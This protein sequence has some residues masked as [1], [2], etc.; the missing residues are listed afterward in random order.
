MIELHKL[1]VDDIVIGERLPW[2]VMDSSARLLLGEGYIID[3]RS[4]AKEL[5]DR[6]AYIEKSL[7]TKLPNFQRSLTKPETEQFVPSTESPSVLH[8][9]NLAVKRLDVL[10]KNIKKFPEARKS[11]LEIVKLIRTAI[12]L[13]ED[14]ALASMQ[15]N[16]EAGSY[17]VRHCVDTAILALIV[18]KAMKKS[19]QEMQD[20]AAA[21]LT[22]NI[23][24]IELQERL[25]IQKGAIS[26]AD[27]AAIHN[28]PISTIEVLYE[29]GI[30]DTDWLMYVLLHHEHEDG[31]GYP[32]GTVKGEIP[33]NAKI[34]SLADGFC[35][36]IT[37]RGYRKS[38]LPSVA[39]R[40]IFIDNVARVD[41]TLGAYFVKVLGLYPPGTFVQL[42]NKE[43]A[44][45]SQRGTTPTNCTA[46]SMVKPNGELF[47]A[48]MK[49]DTSTDPYKI[50]EA[51]YPIDAAVHV[52]LQQIWGS[53][54]S[55]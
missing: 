46:H 32:V 16:H 21:A 18:A 48:P 38:T 22:M 6:G 41:A 45:I 25:Q 7:Y 47:V 8:L 35:A 43:V 44:I 50:A 11:V 28:H 49:R 52:N 5:V 30:E 40:D 36:R 14:L 54:A 15:L 13:S 37:S 10:L 2:N 34:I 27:K 20:I 24:M 42:Q 51:I 26:E 55:L 53:L 9:I 29:A 4:E 12:L 1:E 3:L 19:E 31:T 33:Q 17:A 23:T 39:L